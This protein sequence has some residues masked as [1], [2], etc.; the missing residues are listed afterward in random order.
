MKPKMIGEIIQFRKLIKNRQ[1]SSDELR[2]LQDRRLR[3][4]IQHA[5]KNVPYY[6]ELFNTVGLSPED[7]STVED[8]KHIPITTKDNLR[9]AGVEKIIAKNVSLSSCT[10]VRTSGFTGKSFNICLTKEELR[11]RRLI[12]FRTLLSVGFKYEDRLAVLGPEHQHRTRFHQRLG[13]YRSCNISGLLSLDNQIKNLQKICPTVFWSYPTAL[14][15]LLHSLD[16]RLSN[17]IHPRMLI[18]SAEVFDNGLRKRVMSDLDAE[19]FNFYGALEVG[20]IA[21][22]CPAHEGLHVNADHVI[23]ECVKNEWT[24][25][26]GKSGISVIT[27]L[28]ADAMPFI[29]YELGD[30]C[31][32][33]EKKC[34]CGLSFPLIEPPLGRNEKLITLPSGKML[35]PNVVLFILRSF[36]EI[37]QFRLVQESYDRLVIQI[38][39]QEVY[40]D[41]L[42]DKIR[43]QIMETL[44]EQIKLD[45]RVVDLIEEERLKFRN[46]ISQ[47]NEP[48]L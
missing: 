15:A 8:L 6:H 11:I 34:S 22:E 48:N 41:Q 19:I 28:N 40:P 42:L 45:I 27:A 24:E 38:V 12:E 47:I 31:K 36:D 39:L 18:T 13:F 25:K 5:Y 43:L 4:V 2:E 29:R 7:I 23:L 10:S 46:F 44:G 33:V 14:W 9:A 32:F 17:F 35:S 1:L 16:Y 3:E 26:I 21:A 20:R 37:G 30:I